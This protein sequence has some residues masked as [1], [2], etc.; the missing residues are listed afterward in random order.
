LAYSPIRAYKRYKQNATTRKI[1]KLASNYSRVIVMHSIPWNVQLKQRPHHLASKL[2]EHDLF[3]IYLEPDEA[4]TSFRK[5][6]D[7]FVTTNSLDNIMRLTKRADTHY[8]FFFNNVSNITLDCV[9]E[10]KASGYNIIYEYIDEFH[11]DISGTVTNQLDIW[12]NMKELAPAA[13]LASADKLYN[14]AVKQYKKSRVLLSKNAVNISDFDYHNYEDAEIPGDLKKILLSGH[15]IVGYYGAISPWLNYDLIHKAAKNNP[16]LEFVFIGV[17]YQDSLK[18]L[19]TSIK[20]I[21]FLGPKDYAK[22]PLYSRRF[23]CAMIPFNYGE[24]AKGTSPVKLFEY[25]A[26]GLPTVCTR[27]LLECYGYKHVLISENDEEFSENLKKA[28]ESQ[29]S[30]KT[31]EKLLAQA[32]KNS[33]GSRAN[34]IVDYLDKLESE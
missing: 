28:I 5:V 17:N 11:E 19:D 27:D 12:N 33:W 2:T 10:I 26:M 32:K 3:V 1:Q 15:K 34:D 22:L 18:N 23:N 9:K 31:K 4:I 24:I 20:N 25:M 7:N 21:H 6:S 30:E 16:D 14:D 8:Y 29:D 13:I